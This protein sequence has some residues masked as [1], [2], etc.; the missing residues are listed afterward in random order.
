MDKELV[1][2]MKRQFFGG[3]GKKEQRNSGGVSAVKG[4]EIME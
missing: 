3:V 4:G 1:V 2:R